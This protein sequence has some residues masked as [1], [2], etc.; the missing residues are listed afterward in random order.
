MRALARS[1][2][3]QELAALSK[4]PQGSPRRSLP[5]YSTTSRWRLGGLVSASSPNRATRPGLPQQAWSAH[6][7][8]RTLRPLQT[9]LCARTRISWPKSS[10]LLRAVGASPKATRRLMMPSRARPYARSARCRARRRRGQDTHAGTDAGWPVGGAEV[11][12]LPPC[13]AEPVVTVPRL[14]YA[15]AVARPVAIALPLLPP[16][17]SVAAHGRAQHRAVADRPILWQSVRCRR[18][19]R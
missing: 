9:R 12:V 7:R 17:D 8:V 5:P 14:L 6:A 16:S 15:L 13:T 18:G 1:R 2:P 11:R 10:A 4:H 3:A 19:Q